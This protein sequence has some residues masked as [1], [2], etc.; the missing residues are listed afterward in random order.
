MLVTTV[1]CS[2]NLPPPPLCF[3]KCTTTALEHNRHVLGP[4]CCNCFCSAYNI[5]PYGRGN[6]KNT[7]YFNN[8]W[9]S[10]LIYWKSS[11]LT[12]GELWPTIRGCLGSVFICF[13]FKCSIQPIHASKQAYSSSAAQRHLRRCVR[14]NRDRGIWTAVR[15][16]KE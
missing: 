12:C 5:H 4:L 8:A 3:C 9:V 11:I 16:Q 2:E 6:K 15:C 13:C 10:Q 7:A 1:P 14:R